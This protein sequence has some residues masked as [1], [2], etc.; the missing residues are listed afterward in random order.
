MP[1]GLTYFV[2]PDVAWR[3]EA[4]C[5]TINFNRS[6]GQLVVNTYASN[7]PSGSEWAAL[8]LHPLSTQPHIPWAPHALGPTCPEP[9]C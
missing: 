9:C 3:D 4:L 5:D 6:T 1:A 7:P 2:G 8:Q